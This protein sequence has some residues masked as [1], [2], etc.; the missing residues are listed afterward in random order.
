M[1]LLH[2]LL[3]EADSSTWQWWVLGMVGT[4][5]TGIALEKFASRGR[6]SM[7]VRTRLE[8]KAEQLMDARFEARAN[9]LNAQ[10]RSLVGRV[11]R[12]ESQQGELVRSQHLL[13]IKVV[14]EI[15]QLRL[16]IAERGANK[17]DIESILRAIRSSSPVG[18][19]V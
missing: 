12:L 15:G 9:E 2:S 6:N 7:A 11:D 13:E 18:E 8:R 14:H 19:G 10:H 17:D 4:M 1:N 5:V 16:M 3:A